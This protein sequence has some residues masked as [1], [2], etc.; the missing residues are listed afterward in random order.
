MRLVRPGWSKPQQVRILDSER[1]P[2]CCMGEPE[3]WFWAEY[4]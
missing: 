2:M 3:F 4:A 1:A